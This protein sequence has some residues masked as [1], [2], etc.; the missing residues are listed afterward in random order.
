MGKEQ[1][2]FNQRP[3][4]MIWPT[5]IADP[6]SGV[7]SDDNEIK[8]GHT[9]TLKTNDSTVIVIARI[10]E[11]DRNNYIG[12]IDHFNNHKGEIIDT[13]KGHKE[14]DRIEFTFEEIHVVSLCA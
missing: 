11:I 8:I 12:I 2:Q 9:V 7:N 5:V 1:I 3:N 10:E 14:G 4:I 13:Y 6:A